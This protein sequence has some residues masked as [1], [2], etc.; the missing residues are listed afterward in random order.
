MARLKGTSGNS[1]GEHFFDL[2]SDRPWV[3]IPPGSPFE[4]TRFDKFALNR[5]VSGSGIFV[6]RNGPVH[7]N[8]Q[9]P[10]FANCKHLW[11]ISNVASSAGRFFLQ[12]QADGLANFRGWSG[13]DLK[14]QGAT[15]IFRTVFG[16]IAV[17]GRRMKES[18][19]RCFCQHSG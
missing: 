13:S 2:L 9:H 1:K 14:N 16:Q 17:D 3:R 12:A 8:T 10:V 15:L 11:P 18:I 19:S 6:S 4:D 5:Q 7:A